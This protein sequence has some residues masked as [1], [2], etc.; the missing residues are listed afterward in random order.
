MLSDKNSIMLEVNNK[1]I[2]FRNFRNLEMRNNSKFNV[3]PI[4]ILTRLID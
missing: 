3:I 4:K 1:K 2:N